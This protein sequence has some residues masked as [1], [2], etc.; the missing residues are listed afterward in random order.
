MR[1]DV[2]ERLSQCQRYNIGKS[3][4]HPLTPFTASEP[5][6][7]VAIDTA[8]CFP[9]S[10][11]GNSVFL[12]ITCVASRFVWLRALPDKTAASVALALFSPFLISDSRK[13]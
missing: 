6:E 2:Q 10:P 5:M 12:V 4:Y 11:R 8:L 13:P 3:E 9:V 1:R 7:S